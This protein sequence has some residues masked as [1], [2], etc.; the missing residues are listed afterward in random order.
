MWCNE[1]LLRK[2][3]RYLNSLYTSGN[4]YKH[5]HLFIHQSQINILIWNLA[6]F[7][8]KSMTQNHHIL[9]MKKIENSILNLDMLGSQL[10]NPITQKICCWSPKLKPFLT[11]KLAP[12]RLKLLMP[13]LISYFTHASRRSIAIVQLVVASA[14]LRSIKPA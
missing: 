7:F 3:F 9:T 1:S 8:Y 6:L 14:K 11:A 13:M 5:E 2:A 4:R 12:H 10:I